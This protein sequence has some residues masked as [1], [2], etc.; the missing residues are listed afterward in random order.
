MAPAE[1]R[2]RILLTDQNIDCSSNGRM[3]IRSPSPEEGVPSPK[4][5]WKLIWGPI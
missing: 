4:L 5:T 1:V 2:F 3:D